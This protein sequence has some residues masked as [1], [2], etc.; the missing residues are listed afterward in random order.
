MIPFYY[1]TNRRN[2]GDALNPYLF[3]RVLKIPVKHSPLKQASMTG[4]GSLLQK[5]VAPRYELFKRAGVF[6]KPELQVM[7]SGFIAAV[8]G[9]YALI[10][11]LDIKAIRGLES[12]RIIESI[13]GTPCRAAVG[14][15]GMLYPLLLE[16]QPA[17]KYSLGIIPH[18]RDQ[19]LPV[20]KELAAHF[21]GSVIIDVQGEPLEVLQQIASCERILS[22]SL[23]GLI[24]ADA[25]EIPNRHVHFS[26]NVRGNG[27]KFTD[28]YSV[29]S[30]EDRLPDLQI[31]KI[32]TVSVDALFGQYLS[33]KQRF[34]ELQEELLKAMKR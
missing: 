13:T 24:I 21:K 29:F 2:F 5:C 34:S 15:G 7:S 8:P 19:Q 30:P 14:D 31:A 9:N 26:D 6:F 18:Y 1:S 28:Y 17:K 4:V 11:K 32:M 20:V 12:R 10:R 3:E 16:K 25:L 27:F 22:S 23:H 33:K